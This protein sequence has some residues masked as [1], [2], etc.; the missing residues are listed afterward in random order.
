MKG[1]HPEVGNRGETEKGVREKS[2]TGSHI[3]SMFAYFKGWRHSDFTENGIRQHNTRQ[4][5]KRANKEIRG[6]E[7]RRKAI[8]M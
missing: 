1:T 5:K 2:W 7:K 3:P 4:G 6:T 8:N